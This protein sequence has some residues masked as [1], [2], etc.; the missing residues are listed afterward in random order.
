[1]SGP[2]I[3]SFRADLA[4][5]KAG[6][7]ANPASRGV[8]TEPGLEFPIEKREH[9]ATFLPGSRIATFSY[10]DGTVRVR[11]ASGKVLSSFS[12]G[13]HYPLGPVATDD[14]KRL[15]AVSSADHSVAA[16]D[17]TNGS[18]AWELT[19]P[20]TPDRDEWW[21]V[22]ALRG[23]LV[24]VAKESR[25][26]DVIDGTNGKLIRTLPGVW[27]VGEPVAASRPGAFVV[28]EAR[29][30]VSLVDATSGARVW[31]VDATRAGTAARAFAVE[32]G[33]DGGP[34]LCF[35]G[36]KSARDLVALDSATGR[37]SWRL[38]SGRP[39]VTVS[40][41]G[42]YALLRWTQRPMLVDLANGRDL[43][44]LRPPCTSDLVFFGAD[45]RTLWVPPV[46][47]DHPVLRSFR[48][49]LPDDHAPPPK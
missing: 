33:R 12:M 15:I 11:D 39:S 29:S 4:K 30:R 48:L 35:F 21:R 44:R 41:S 9:V 22:A 25:T 47:D 34:V 31:S 23:G 6:W 38:P 16:F 14:G 45:D 40:P 18:K 36:D 32:C 1:M 3:E 20:E 37:E 13:E 5:A 26:I 17:P 46:L 49:R 2:E 24:V 42:H 19:A 7:A 43:G 10:D 28:V 27:D 8:A